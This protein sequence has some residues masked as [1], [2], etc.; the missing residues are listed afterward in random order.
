[1]FRSKK[2]ES[3]NFHTRHLRTFLTFGSSWPHLLCFC[4]FLVCRASIFW[5]CWPR[6]EPRSSPSSQKPESAEFGSKTWED[7]SERWRNKSP[8]WSASGL[9]KFTYFSQQCSTLYYYSFYWPWS[10]LDSN[11]TQTAALLRLSLTALYSF[12]RAVLPEAGPETYG[13]WCNWYRRW[14]FSWF[15]PG[16]KNCPCR[17]IA[18]A[19]I[20]WSCTW[21]SK[22][23]PI[24]K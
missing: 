17:F 22:W 19:D 18:R 21:S 15:C 2:Y 20:F 1:M 16:G 6:T 3:L 7:T 10:D 13:T 23:R 9:T 12:D 4:C 24:I 11:L 14:V 8:G 5:T